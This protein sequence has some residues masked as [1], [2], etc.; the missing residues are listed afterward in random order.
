MNPRAI[1]ST[2]QRATM[3]VRSTPL[4]A[5][6]GP[7]KGEYSVRAKRRAR[8]RSG[9]VKRGLPSVRRE[10]FGDAGEVV[11]VRESASA[12][13]AEVREQRGKIARDPARREHGLSRL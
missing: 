13:F 6:R 11:E 4:Q 12:S 8:K 5:W 3:F 1:S 10:G 9:G 2:R 7:P